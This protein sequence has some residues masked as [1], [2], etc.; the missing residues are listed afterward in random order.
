MRI[1]FDLYKSTQ[2]GYKVVTRDGKPVRIIRTD[3]KSDH[4]NIVVLVD[5]GTHESVLAYCD[6]GVFLPS[7]R[8]SDYDL[9]LEVESKL[10][11]LLKDF[12]LIYSQREFDKQAD[13]VREA[14]KR[15]LI[16]DGWTNEKK[17]G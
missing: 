9:F 15:E 5:M 8:E 14:V 3:R 11:E 4:A 12:R 6:D 10:D 1:P 17:E 2:K 13:R 16:A 7:E